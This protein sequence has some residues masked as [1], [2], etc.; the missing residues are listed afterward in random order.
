MNKII[1]ILLS[2]VRVQ[3]CGAERVAFGDVEPEVLKGVYSLA[4]AHDMAHVVAAELEAQGLLPAVGDE[5]GDKLRKQ[6]MLAIF[7]YERISYEL[8][9][10]CRVFESNGIQHMPLKGSV[11]RRYYTEPWM[12]TSSDIDI[13]VHPENLEKAKVVLCSE[14]DYTRG[15]PNGTEYNDSMFSPS[16]VHLELHYE[17]IEEGKAVNSNAVMSRVWDSAYP[18]EGWSYR[19]L[20]ADEVFYF[21]HIAHMVKHFEESGCGLRFFLD[22][23]L[24]DTRVEH[25]K[26]KRDAL[27]KEGGLLAFAE[28][29]RRL[30]Q[31]WLAE[32]EHDDVTRLMEQYVLRG[33]VYGVSFNKMVNDQRKQGGKTAY[34]LSRIFLPYSTLKS[35]FPVLEK[36]KWLYPF[37]QV[38]R[39]FRLLFCGGVKR[40][41]NELVANANVTEE[42]SDSAERMFRALGLK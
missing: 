39:W 36:H 11:I 13:L 26:E 4:K 28:S 8:E 21:Y 42:Q 41:V 34:A 6:H 30:A 31:V 33:G 17:T 14:L 38:V 37:M 25:S 12:R 35:Y 40:S 7:R 20:A 18:D 3:A 16:G 24:L 15:E 27:L 29:A 19:L 10:I 1:D 9:E 32:G 2:S 22:L 5:I 23:W